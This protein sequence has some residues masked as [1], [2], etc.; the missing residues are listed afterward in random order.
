[1]RKNL[2]LLLLTLTALLPV[3]AQ[4]LLGNALCLSDVYLWQQGD[5]LY[6]SMKM[7]FD[8]LSLSP[9]QSLLLTPMLTDGTHNLALESITV[10]GRHRH[11]LFR[12]NVAQRKGQ[13]AGIVVPYDP[14][15]R[16]NYAEAI[17]Y[18]PWMQHAAFELRENIS[19]GDQESVS[20]ELITKNI[21][22]EASR[23]AA[24]VPMVAYIRSDAETGERTPDAAA[25]LN[26][27]A[28]AL[29]A[30]DF[31]SAQRLLEKADH[32]TAEYINNLGIYH[33]LTGDLTQSSAHFRQAARMGN[34]SA[35]TN[36][37]RL[38]Y[39]LSKHPQSTLSPSR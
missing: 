11:R 20:Q 14:R 1:M 3:R 31:R 8:K 6:I 5:S 15:T 12:R 33:L 35:R 9:K 26:A 25:N 27:A 16:L 7:N 10:N 28:V 4:M 30:K 24:F 37:S 21:S 34:L 36:L 19:G 23:L 18:E 22:T 39:L 17:P 2:L 13:P 38:Q 32:Q 29:E